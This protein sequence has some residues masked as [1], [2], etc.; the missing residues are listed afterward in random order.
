M[1]PLAIA[2]LTAAMLAAIKTGPDVGGKMPN[3][4]AV[5]QNG[6]SHK[7]SELL[8]PKGAVL[9]AYRSADW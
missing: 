4:A 1:R 8:G 5:D 2:L 6:K 9:V 7:L 3:F